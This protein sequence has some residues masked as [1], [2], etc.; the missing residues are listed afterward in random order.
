MKNFIKILKQ[1]ENN[2]HEKNVFHNGDRRT[3]EQWNFIGHQSFSVAEGSHY[4][5][6]PHQL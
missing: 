2:S 5:N 6:N 4:F 3:S 1:K